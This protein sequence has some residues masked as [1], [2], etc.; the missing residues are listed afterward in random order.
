MILQFKNLNSSI[1]LS[2]A[3]ETKMQGLVEHIGTD[4]VEVYFIDEATIERYLRKH[5]YEGIGHMDNPITEWL[6]FY[7]RGFDRWAKKEY[8]SI[9]LCLE[10]IEMLVSTQKE[11]EYLVAKV[12]IHEIA[13]ML[14]DRD[15]LKNA[16]SLR[17]HTV[18]E[19]L[20]ESFANLY[21]LQFFK[22]LRN[23]AN[24]YFDEFYDFDEL[25]FYVVSF[26]RKQ[27]P[28]YRFGYDLFR[29]GYTYD[30]WLNGRA[31]C[32]LLD[33]DESRRILSTIWSGKGDEEIVEAMRPFEE[34]VRLKEALDMLRQV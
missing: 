29:L 22:D 25:F 9:Y 21:T 27:P 34:K 31:T 33:H 28:Q 12:L 13:H 15:D 1:E 18:C 23:G 4:R 11:F 30:L 2:P 8:A 32:A 19:T 10:K 26:V 16:R 7:A 24:D 14:F 17:F 5:K 20:E 3:Q 6:G